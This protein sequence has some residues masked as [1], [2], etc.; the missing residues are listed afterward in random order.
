MTSNSVPLC[1]CAVVILM[2]L[3]ATPDVHADE[4]LTAPTNLRYMH[5]EVPE[6]H[7]E[8]W[9]RFGHK[10]GLPIRMEKFQA[11]LNAAQADP[12]RVQ[13][14]PAA[15]RFSLLELSGELIDG[16][17]SGT[18]RIEVQQDGSAASFVDM[19]RCGIAISNARWEGGGPASWRAP[20]SRSRSGLQHLCNRSRNALIYSRYCQTYG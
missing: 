7:P 4:E 8:L 3:G 1:R 13:L 15:P 9:P 5:I 14:P 20:E 19:N 16:A 12:R 18:G 2:T 11:L 10:F 17:F 6:D